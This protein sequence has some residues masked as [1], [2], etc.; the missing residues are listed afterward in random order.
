MKKVEEHEKKKLEDNEEK[1]RMKEEI[2]E[3][4]IFYYV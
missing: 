2:R 1:V 3:M 4:V